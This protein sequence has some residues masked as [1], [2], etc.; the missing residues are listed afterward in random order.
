MY[1]VIAEQFDPATGKVIH[2]QGWQYHKVQVVVRPGS[3]ASV[4]MDQTLGR[5]VAVYMIGRGCGSGEEQH[6]RVRVFE[7]YQL[8]Q[9]L[10]YK[11]TMKVGEL[12][13]I[14]HRPGPLT[15]RLTKWWRTVTGQ[16]QPVTRMDDAAARVADA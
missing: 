15:R 10:T 6:H 8:D 2:E 5:N 9:S 13:H 11:G 3:I 12:V 14:R 4:A 7:D 16:P 1:Q